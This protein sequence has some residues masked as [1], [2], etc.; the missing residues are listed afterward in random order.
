M[1]VRQDETRSVGAGGRGISQVS[2]RTAIVWVV[3]VFGDTPRVI[4]WVVGPSRWRPISSDQSLEMCVEAVTGRAGRSLGNGTRGKLRCFLIWKLRD[5][6]LDIRVII[7][8]LV[9]R[10]AFETP[11]IGHGFSLTI[12]DPYCTRTTLRGILAGVADLT[13]RVPKPG[14]D[15]QV[16]LPAH[17]FEG[18]RL[19]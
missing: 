7:S 14:A 10:I 3:S 9:T 13:H 11:P 5:L 2:V 1:K 18:L 4:R 8:G 16:S 17:G 12:T 15:P 6:L 19:G